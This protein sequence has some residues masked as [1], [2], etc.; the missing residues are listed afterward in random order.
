MTYTKVGFIGLGNIGF[1]M[2]KNMVKDDGIV[3][4]V[5]DINQQ[6]VKSMSEL[7]A[8]AC[9]SPKEVAEKSDVVFLSLPNSAIVEKVILG[10]GG[11]Q[12][13]LSSGGTIVDLS[14]AEPS[15]TRKIAGI[16]SEKGI[17]LLDAPVAGGTEG[18]AV[19]KLSIMVGG[20]ENRLND[21]MPLFKTIGEKII[22]V[23]PIG[24]GH[25]LKAINNLLYATIMVA[26]F[27]AVTLGVKAGIEAN[28]MI[29]VLSAS[30]GR[31]FVVDV[32]FNS[33]LSRDFS[34]KFTTNLLLKD[35]DIALSL[36]KEKGVP[37]SLNK[38]AQ[39]IVVRGQQKGFGELDHT[40][41]IKLYEEPSGVVVE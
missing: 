22:Y 11:V 19:G 30:S 23:G 17:T 8:N 16:L 26:S 41:I 25:A 5:Y 9:L 13:G 18:A 29:E 35:M 1:L 2:A 33:I 15:S 27:E 31:N 39:Q 12:E 37:L 36:A 4:N 3:L 21:I 34:P 24:S 6:A 20:H 32:K 38:F 40:A 14:S 7:G 28:K 10:E